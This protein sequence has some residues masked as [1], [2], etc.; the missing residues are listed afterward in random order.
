MKNCEQVTNDLLER[1]DKYVAEQRRKKKRAMGMVTSLCC[2]C[3]V[4]L[5]G[6]GIWQGGWF[7]PTQPDQSLED[8]LYL[9]LIHI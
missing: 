8:S 4:A 7:A 3:L 1:R 6:I 2:V 5:M 9:S